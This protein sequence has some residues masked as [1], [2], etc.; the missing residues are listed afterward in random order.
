MIF[1]HYRNR[2]L[3]TAVA[4]PLI[5]RIRLYDPAPHFVGGVELFVVVGGRFENRMQQGVFCEGLF[6]PK[7][8]HLLT[9]GKP[10]V[11]CV[12]CS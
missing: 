10:V 11:L 12:L 6:T 5:E 1:S 8:A 3:A 4:R 2:R 9:T 7:R